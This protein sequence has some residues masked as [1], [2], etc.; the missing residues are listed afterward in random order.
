[1]LLIKIEKLLSQYNNAV[2]QQWMM[3]RNYTEGNFELLIVINV[4]FY[5]VNLI[6]LEKRSDE[7][8][9]TIRIENIKDGQ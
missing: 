6:M 2:R 9:W 8:I 1:M 3:E 4:M 5:L 7:I